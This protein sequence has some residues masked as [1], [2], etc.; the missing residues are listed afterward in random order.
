VIVRKIGWQGRSRGLAIREQLEQRFQQWRLGWFGARL[1]NAQVLIDEPD[2]LVVGA[3]GWRFANAQSG[4]WMLTSDDAGIRLAGEALQLPARGMDLVRRVGES[5]LEDLA[6]SLWGPDSNG[7]PGSVRAAPGE[8]AAD[9]LRY[10]GLAYSI[11]GLPI[12]VTILVDRGW[13]DA[14]IPPQPSRRLALTDR[15]VAIGSTRVVLKATVDLGEIPLM[16]S[17]GW[18]QGELLLTDAA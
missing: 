17:T 10:G 14:Q 4:M 3:L 7:K 13:C 6:L 5:C 11:A 2:E 16:E 8:V 18:S 9:L 12:D 15:R 1:C